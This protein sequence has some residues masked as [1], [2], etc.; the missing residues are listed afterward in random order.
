M[1]HLSVRELKAALDGLRVDYRDCQEKSELVA[2]LLAANAQ[3]RASAPP[4]AA[5]TS[6]SAGSAA[7][8]PP[9][10]ASSADA[11]GDGAVKSE[12]RRILSLAPGDY[13]GILGVP[14]GSSDEDAIKK[15]YRK[16]ALRLHPDKCSAAGGEEAFKRVS[17]A[18]AV[19]KD[20]RQRAS[21]NM[22]GSD[23]PTAGGGGGGGGF[24]GHRPAGFS[25][26]V[27]AE[28]LFRAFFG[29]GGARGGGAGGGGSV[30]GGAHVRQRHAGGPG[31]GGD[32][33]DEGNVLARLV[34]A[35]TRNPWT[36]VTA[37][38]MLSTVV[39]FLETLVRWVGMEM[40]IIFA[41]VG[42]VIWATPSAG[43]PTRGGGA[44]GGRRP[45]R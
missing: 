30:R 32:D 14:K 34:R 15:S 29:G 16:L 24:A 19:L 3:R 6:G 12:I 26:D 42:A 9:R 13:Y 37:L 5:P 8:P 18:F 39:G 35:F 33:D 20:S 11:G 41:V 28:E 44:G 36:L 31:G 40:L 17:S 2:R 22:F 10:R 25:R 43:N 4:A 1:A 45:A 27:D 21:F 38:S 7:S 23:E